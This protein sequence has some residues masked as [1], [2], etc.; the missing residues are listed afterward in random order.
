MTKMSRNFSSENLV[1]GEKFRNSEQ[2]YKKRRT[3]L[4]TFFAFGEVKNEKM[5]CRIYLREE[6]GLVLQKIQIIFP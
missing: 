6:M 5:V 4:K 1:E 2:F 3:I